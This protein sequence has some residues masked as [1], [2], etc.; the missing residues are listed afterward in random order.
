MKILIANIGSTS[1]K[2]RLLEGADAEELSAKQKLLRSAT[3]IKRLRR[4]WQRRAEQSRLIADHVKQ[5]PYPVILAGDLNDNPLSYAYQTLTGG[6]KDAFMESGSGFGF[7]Y[8]GPIPGLNIKEKFHSLQI[9]NTDF[10][11]YNKKYLDHYPHSA[12]K[13]KKK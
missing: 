5:S 2:Y 13:K 1:F 11:I 3:I 8:A 7:T 10:S 6:L 9:G 12:R 4:G